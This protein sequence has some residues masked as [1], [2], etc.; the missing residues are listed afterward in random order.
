MSI[1]YESLNQQLFNRFPVLSEPCYTELIGGIEAGPYVTFGVLF[2]RLLVDVM[3]NIDHQTR[4]EAAVFIEEMSLAED[5]R[6]SQ[7]LVSEVLPTLT[8]NQQI[9]SIFWPL[10][11]ASTRRRLRV[12][13]PRFIANADLPPA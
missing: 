10:F 4:R 6:I 8:Q 13:E 7:L 1:T 11:G 9:L 3:P 5:E 2:N 12:L